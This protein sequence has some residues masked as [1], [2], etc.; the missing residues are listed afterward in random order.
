VDGAANE[1]LLRLLAAELD[2]PRTS[3]AIVRGA[4]GRRK[5]VDLTSPDAQ[6]ARRRWPDIKVS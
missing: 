4:T 5:L 1:A 6:G 2:M 3:L